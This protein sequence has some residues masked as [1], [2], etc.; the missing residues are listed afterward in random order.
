MQARQDQDVTMSVRL[1]YI[2]PAAH[3]KKKKLREK[4]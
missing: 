3:G 4:K 2:G 1:A